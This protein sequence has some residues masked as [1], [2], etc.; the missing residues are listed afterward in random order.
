MNAERMHKCF[1]LKGINRYFTFSSCLP[2]ASLP[3]LQLN[4]LESYIF[5]KTHGNIQYIVDILLCEL[6]S[7]TIQLCF[8][9][10]MASEAISEHLISKKFLGG[11]RPQTPLIM[12]MHV[13]IH[14]GHPCNPPSRNP[15]YEPAIVV[16][17]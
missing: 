15:S 12:L 7:Y 14:F 8:C 9:P 11:A 13:Y 5:P 17:K 6:H 2:S 10:K 3:A 1:T 16:T 4:S